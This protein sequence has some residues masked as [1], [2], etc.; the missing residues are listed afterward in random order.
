M[1]IA[2]DGR[3]ERFQRIRKNDSNQEGNGNQGTATAND[4]GGR[5][6]SLCAWIREMFHFPKWSKRIYNIVRQRFESNYWL[7][8]V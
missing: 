2:T 3:N 5:I 7:A 8:R 6:T 4:K 1:A